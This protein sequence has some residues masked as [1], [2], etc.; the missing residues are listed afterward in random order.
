MVPSMATLSAGHSWPIHLRGEVSSSVDGSG[1]ALSSLTSAASLSMNGLPPSSL[2]NH[3]I[4]SS[5]LFNWSLGSLQSLCSADITKVCRRRQ[6]KNKT[7]TAIKHSRECI[8]TKATRCLVS[9][10]GRPF[11]VHLRGRGVL[12]SGLVRSGTFLPDLSSFIVNKRVAPFLLA[13]QL[14]DRV[15]G[16]IQLVAR[17][18]LLCRYN[19]SVQTKADKEQE[20]NSN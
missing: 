12:L 4:E 20:I 6:T 13:Y 1:V 11:L 10:I 8:L 2:I 15:Q 19:R 17:V 3:S 7:S 18:T 14:L 9:R 5:M 16:T